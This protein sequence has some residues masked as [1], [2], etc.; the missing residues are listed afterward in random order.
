MKD[1]FEPITTLLQQSRIAFLATTGKSGAEASMAPF[2]LYDG[3]ILLHLSGL[4]A[5]TA[6]IMHHAQMGLIVCTPELAGAPLALPRLSLQGEAS[7]LAAQRYDQAKA[8]YLQRIP[9]AEMLFSFADFRL[10]A[11][12]PTRIHWVGGFGKAYD[13][14]QAQWREI[15]DAAVTA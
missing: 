4:A 14:S 9:D 5:H 2:A 12:T 15:A 1:N 6:N 8:A 10:F 13:I 7:M 11:L 3:M